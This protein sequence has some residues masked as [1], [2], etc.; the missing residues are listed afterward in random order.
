MWAEATA[1]RTDG[2]NRPAQ[3][4]RGRRSGQSDGSARKHELPDSETALELLDKMLLIR[5]F[6]E[7]AQEMYMKAKIGGFLHLAVGEEAT[8]VGTDSVLRDAG[9]PDHHLPRAR[10]GDRR[11]APTRSS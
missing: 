1:H 9:L 3:Q 6:E 11:A 2:A 4:S 7:R 8:I 10:P 5:H